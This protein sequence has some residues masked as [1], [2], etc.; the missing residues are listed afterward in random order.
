MSALLIAKHKEETAGPS[1]EERSMTWGTKQLS[2]SSAQHKLV[3]DHRHIVIT[4]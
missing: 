4:P 2:V 3:P 1:P